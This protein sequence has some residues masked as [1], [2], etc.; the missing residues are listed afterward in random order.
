MVAADLPMANI[1]RLLGQS[2]RE[3]STAVL[4]EAQDLPTGE[5]VAVYATRRTRT[6]MLYG[7]DFSR[8]VVYLRVRNAEEMREEMARQGIKYVYV[9]VESIA[10]KAGIQ[11]LVDASELTKISP[12]LYRL[13]R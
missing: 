6:F 12:R 10:R 4:H 5:P 8:K 3:R 7:P 11:A 1:A 2:W 13:Q 9:N